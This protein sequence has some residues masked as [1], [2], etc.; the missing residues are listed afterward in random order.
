MVK[1]F[2]LLQSRQPIG[3]HSI[4][5][6]VPA[7]AAI[8]AEGPSSEKNSPGAI[9]RAIGRRRSLRRTASSIRAARSH[10]AR[11]RAPGGSTF[12]VSGHRRRAYFL[13]TIADRRSSSHVAAIT[14]IYAHHVLHGLASFEIEPP[15]EDDMRRR[16]PQAPEHLPIAGA[17]FKPITEF[18]PD[19]PLEG[20]GFRTSGSG[21]RG[22]G[23]E[24]RSVACEG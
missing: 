21:E 17:P 12:R 20:D 7:A 18:V 15:S 24:P 23:F 6:A 3:D 14:A 19:F 5:A 2:A 22:Q 8:A 9:E 4:S 16:L 13:Q 10:L 1:L 11:C